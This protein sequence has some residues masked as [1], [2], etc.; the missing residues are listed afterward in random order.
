MA[1]ETA[2]FSP[3]NPIPNALALQIAQDWTVAQASHI[4]EWSAHV[5]QMWEMRV[6]PQLSQ[7]Q[8]CLQAEDK[9]FFVK[10]LVCY[11]LIYHPESPVE[12]TTVQFPGVE[13]NHR[14]VRA[15]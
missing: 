5:A 13:Q 6:V 14:G 12:L 7:V 1:S 2:K 10:A 9:G 4:S 15:K 8:H 11:G 3:S